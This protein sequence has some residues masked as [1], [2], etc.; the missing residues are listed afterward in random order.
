VLLN[1]ACCWIW[2]AAEFGV[3]PNLA[4]YWIWCAAE[5]GVLLNLVCCCIWCAAEFGVLLNFMVISHFHLSSLSSRV[6]MIM[7]VYTR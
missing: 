4:C 6:L 2:R 7:N 3:L 1:L 5:F